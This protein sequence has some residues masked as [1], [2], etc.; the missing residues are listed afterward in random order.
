M[1]SRP[2]QPQAM[3]DITPLTEAQESLPCTL[4]T[5]T[6]TPHGA[7]HIADSNFF[8]ILHKAYCTV[9]RPLKAETAFLPALTT[10]ATTN[11][12]RTNAD[13]SL[14]E[15]CTLAWQTGKASGRTSSGLP[16]SEGRAAF[17]CT[18]RGSACPR[19]RRPA[20]RKLLLLWTPRM[21]R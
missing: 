13:L 5:H 19:L 6:H 14:L 15:G 12:H 2:G 20:T 11:N 1:H 17:M 4:H 21:T 10:T 16:W 8:F 18:R 7:H 3:E 9:K